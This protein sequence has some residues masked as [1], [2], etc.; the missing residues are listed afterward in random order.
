MLAGKIAI[1]G[2]Q[3]VLQQGL[4]RIVEMIGGT[5]GDALGSIGTD[6]IQGDFAGVWQTAVA[7]M[8]A[9]WDSFAAGIVE[10][11]A[12]V[13]GK[14]KELWDAAVIGIRG[15]IAGLRGIVGAT[16][17]GT[18]AGAALD[19]LLSTADTAASPTMTYPACAIELY[20]NSRF[21][22]DWTSASR[23]PAD[24]ET[25]ATM[26]KINDQLSL[27]TGSGRPSKKIRSTTA[28][29]AALL[30]TLRNAVTGVGDPV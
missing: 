19:T 28:K 30:A 17:G 2:L 9:T 1:T 26:A 22:F 5:L 11:M 16:L 18:K 10:V 15:S 27:I 7:G 12:A 23:L 24:I 4:L 20:P 25:A 3:L 14:I 29:P 13:V 6:L 8:A 21:M